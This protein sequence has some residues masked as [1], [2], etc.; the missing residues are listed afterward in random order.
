MAGRRPGVK[1]GWCGRA[2]AARRARGRR[3]RRPARRFGKSCTRR[4]LSLVEARQSAEVARG[5]A[6]VA[7]PSPNRLRSGHY[8]LPTQI[9][10]SGRSIWDPRLI[11][12]ATRH[13]KVRVPREPRIRRGPLAEAERGSAAG[14]D[15]AGVPAGAAQ[16]RR[17]ARRAYLERGRRTVSHRSE[18]WRRGWDSNPRS[19]STLRFSRAPPSTARPPL[20]ARG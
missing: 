8:V 4:T 15:D 20:R 18:V 19:L 11:P 17:R 12:D 13:G 9:L 16:T 2:H 3:T 14:L 7:V 1:R 10:P 6:L 5:D